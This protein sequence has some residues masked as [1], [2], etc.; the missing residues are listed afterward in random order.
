MILSFG[1]ICKGTIAQHITPQQLVLKVNEKKNT[2]LKATVSK[3][4]EDNNL[5]ET[6]TT[7]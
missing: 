1:I 2:Y 4:K 6:A 7:N 3:V 5:K